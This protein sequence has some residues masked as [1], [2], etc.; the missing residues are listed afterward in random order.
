MAGALEMTCR[1]ASNHGY[2]CGKVKM[3][4]GAL[5]IVYTHVSRY[6]L[7]LSSPKNHQAQYQSGYWEAFE[8]SKTNLCFGLCPRRFKSCLRRFFLPPKL[9]EPSRDAF[10][11]LADRH[12]FQDFVI[13]RVSRSI[14]LRLSQT[15]L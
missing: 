5:I 7:Q 10:F 3:T 14:L 15:C 12:P 11:L 2:L 1:K 8:S 13:L 4:S 9:Q 6:I